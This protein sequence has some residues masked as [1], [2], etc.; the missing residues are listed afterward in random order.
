[1]N[2]FNNFVSRLVRTLASPTTAPKSSTPR[3][4]ALAYAAALAD[5][6]RHG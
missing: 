1:M 5:T 4:L 6:R 2:N 3:E